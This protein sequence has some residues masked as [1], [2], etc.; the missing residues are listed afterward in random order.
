MRIGL[1]PLNRFSIRKQ[2]LSIKNALV[3]IVTLVSLFFSYSLTMVTQ[4]GLNRW[5]RTFVS[6]RTHT[7][8]TSDMTFIKLY[9]VPCQGISLC[10]HA[11]SVEIIRVRL[12]M[13]FDQLSRI[14]ILRSYATCI[15]TPV[16]TTHSCTLCSYLLY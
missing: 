2:K 13:C 10:S 7:I 6:I 9:V 5:L 14:N 15:I 1:Y 3:T 11:I 4:R 16:Q 8:D 12:M